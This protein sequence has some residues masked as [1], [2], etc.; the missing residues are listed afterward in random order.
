MLKVC[1]NNDYF[2]S[3]LSV[4]TAVVFRIACFFTF[5]TLGFYLLLPDASTLS[6]GINVAG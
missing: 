3:F 6:L 2:V 4:V 5:F 1:G